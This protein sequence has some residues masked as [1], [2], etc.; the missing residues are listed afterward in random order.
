[1]SGE[2]WTVASDLMDKGNEKRVYKH[3]V[4]RQADDVAPPQPLTSCMTWHHYK[5][6][7]D[8]TIVCSQH[9]LTR[10]TC[11][12][13]PTLLAGSSGGGSVA[14]DAHRPPRLPLPGHGDQGQGPAHAAVLPP[15]RAQRPARTVRTGG[16]E[17]GTVMPHARQGRQTQGQAP[18]SCN[19][20][21]SHNPLTDRL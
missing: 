3:K 2:S 17:K 11:L 19:G 14:L 8:T 21:D 12:T 16:D 18:L 6:C 7:G 13:A 1:M 4:R 15:A 5:P 9:M 20:S 10:S